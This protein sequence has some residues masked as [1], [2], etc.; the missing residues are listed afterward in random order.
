VRVIKSEHLTHSNAASAVNQFRAFS[1]VEFAD[2]NITN[3]ALNEESLE[4]VS[5]L[6]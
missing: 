3:A 2:G 5:F 4:T 1:G 6:G